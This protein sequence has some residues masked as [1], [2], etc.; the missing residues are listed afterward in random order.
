MTPIPAR[1]RTSRD[2]S[3]RRV[4]G[5][6]F[7]LATVLFAAAATVLSSTFDWPDILRERP[8]TVLTQFNDGGTTLVWTWFAV[9]WTYFLLLPPILLLGRV[10]APED[11]RYLPAATLIGA[12]SIV[13]STV[14]FLR[15][16]FVVPELARSYTAAATDTTREAVTAAYVAQHQFG[17]A[18]LGEHLGQIL[19]IV[20]TIVVS[21]AMFH[22][23]IFKRWLGWLG[24]AASL[25]YLLNQG[26]VLATAVPGFP[27]IEIAGLLGSTLWAV[28]LLL[29]GASL[30]RG[31][32]GR[33]E[34]AT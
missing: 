22:S 20:W 25:V 15:W 8:S 17:G 5:W 18:L 9:A 34:P 11:H 21:V 14:G 31:A 4:A 26:E 30:V 2:A 23:A 19:A 33:R 24:I 16:V 12:F 13:A 29:L 3:L 7:I 28:W 1:E 27:E 6:L 32:S 10:L